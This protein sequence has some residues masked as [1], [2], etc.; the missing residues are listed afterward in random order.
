[1]NGDLSSQ[2]RQTFSSYKE[3]D[4]KQKQEIESFKDKLND[5]VNKYND[6]RE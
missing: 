3:L 6:L 1:M 5:M 2:I 4:R